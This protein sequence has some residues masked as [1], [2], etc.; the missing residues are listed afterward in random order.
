MLYMSVKTCY[1]KRLGNNHC[2]VL[3][4]TQLDLLYNRPQL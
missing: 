1:N 2:A 4:I 3:F